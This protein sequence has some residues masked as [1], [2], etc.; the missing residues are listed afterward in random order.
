MDSSIRSAREAAGYSQ[1]RLA[2][3]AGTAQTAI[4]A[5]ETGAKEPSLRTLRRLL[6]A[7]GHRLAIE[8]LPVEHIVEPSTRQL[9]Q[10]GKRLVDVIALAQALPVRHDAALRYPRLPRQ[11]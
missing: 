3:E 9:A 4:S 7:T 1:A 5:Y 6:A 8:P 10:A 11:K 2:A